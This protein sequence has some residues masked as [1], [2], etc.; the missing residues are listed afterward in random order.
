MF[1]EFRSKEKVIF[2]LFRGDKY[3]WIEFYRILNY[4]KLENDYLNYI[5]WSICVFSVLFSMYRYVEIII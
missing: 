4:V 3:Y 2:L 5:V 1:N